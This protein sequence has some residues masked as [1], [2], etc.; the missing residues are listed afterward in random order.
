MARASPSIVTTLVTKMLIVRRW[1]TRKTRARVVG[2]VKPATS[3]GRPAATSVPKT[4]T[5]MIKA[6]GSE[7][8]SALLRSRSDWADMAALSGALPVSCTFKPGGVTISF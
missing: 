2:M 3:S 5:R 1:A 8:V 7:M 4:S 6:M